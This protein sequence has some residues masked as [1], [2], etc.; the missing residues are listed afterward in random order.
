MVRSKWLVLMVVAVG[1]VVVAGGWALAQRN[2]SIVF[3]QPWALTS[4]R[5]QIINSI[6]QD[7]MA[8]YRD[9]D[10]TIRDSVPAR[11]KVLTEIIAGTAAD[12]VMIPEDWLHILA[13]ERALLK[14]DPFV[15]NWDPAKRDDF[16]AAVWQLG[17]FKGDQYAVP[18]IAHSMCLIYNKGMFREAGLDPEK[19]PTTW[20]ELLWA[21]EKLTIPDK[22]YGFGLV[23]LQSHDLAWYWYIFLHQAGGQ[24]VR[25]RAGGGWEVAM[26]SP[27]GLEALEFYLRLRQV[28]PPEAGVS[29]AGHLSAQFEAGRIAMFLLGPWAVAGVRTRA[30]H[31]E[32]GVALPPRR[33]QLATIVGSGL[34]V[35]PVTTRAAKQE[36]AWKLISYLTEVGPQVKLASAGYAFRIPTRQAALKDPWFKANPEFMVFVE[37]LGYGVVPYPVMEYRMVHE[38]VVQVELNKAFIGDKTA[39]QALATIEA[40]G[41]R[42]LR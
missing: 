8:A 39:L 17:Q 25:Q 23:G 24:L 12:V 14:L 18:W 38:T 9:I 15:A 33:E 32:V 6:I 11:E 4:E 28:A 2:V 19:P 10:V 29:H 36:A 20:A 21:A 13:N 31:I 5:G 41:N 16:Y 35:I 40:E 3:Q 7:F 34:V 30:P 1:L 37:A 27:A 42:L 26:N 22:Q